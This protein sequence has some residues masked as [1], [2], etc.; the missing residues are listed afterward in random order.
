MQLRCHRCQANR[1]Q[2][3]CR[4]SACNGVAQHSCDVIVVWR[5]ACNAVMQHSC[6][7]VV[8]RRTTCN[9]IAQY[10][11]DPIVR[12]T[13]RKTVT[14]GSCDAIVVGRI[15]C[16]RSCD[17][18]V[19]ERMSCNTVAQYSWKR[20]LSVALR[21]QLRCHH[22][23]KNRLHCKYTIQLRPHR[24]ANRQHRGHTAQF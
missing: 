24:E 5:I 1:L 20:S 14:Q 21:V 7:A 12:R 10:S 17:A 13:T 2:H 23:Q 15:A 8:R 3:T 22:F 4:R 6:D 19:F 16:Q 11:C 9:T 18:I